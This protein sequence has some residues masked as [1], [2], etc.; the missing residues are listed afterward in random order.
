VVGTP[1]DAI[2]QI[3]RLQEKQGDFGVFLQLAHNWADFDKTKASYEL[4]RR[5]VH[6]A[7]NNMND[8][9]QDS[10]EWCTDNASEFI[11]AALNAASATIAKH[12]AATSEAAA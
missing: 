11:G 1:D 8:T 2:A 12:N 3:R 9:R 6:P 7:V 5:H 10:F 4:W